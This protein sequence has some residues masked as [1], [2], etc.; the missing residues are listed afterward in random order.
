M[1]RRTFPQRE[2]GVTQ[3]DPLSPNIFN[4]VV[5]AMVRHWESLMAE[6]EGE[7]SRGNNGDREKTAGRM[8]WDR[9]DGRQRAEERHKRLT[10]KAA[11]FYAD[12]GMVESTDLGWI[13][14]AFDTLKGMFDQ[15][16]LWMSVS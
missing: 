13:Q 8:I 5:G 15:V 6:Q 16:E 2:R 9:D 14:S 11:F 10:V 1:L 3:G 7:Y 12:Y 4:V